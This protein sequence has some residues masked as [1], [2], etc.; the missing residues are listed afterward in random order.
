MREKDIEN[1]LTLAVKKAGGI[2]LKFVSPGFAGMP[3]RIVLLSD[4]L[5]AF[6]ELKA[7]GKKPRPLQLARHRLLR[8]L[9]FKVYVIDSV[10]Q[11]GRMLDELQAT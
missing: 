8:S 6:A 3:D 2:A 4:G 9:G 10:K 11:I 1:K 5:I 7:P